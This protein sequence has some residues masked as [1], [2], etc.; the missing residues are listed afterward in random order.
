MSRPTHTDDTIDLLIA[1]DIAPKVLRTLSP[2]PSLPDLFNQ[3]S[4]SDDVKEISYLQVRFLNAA[5]WH[6]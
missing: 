5:L 3:E 2:T 1:D 6:F 4:D